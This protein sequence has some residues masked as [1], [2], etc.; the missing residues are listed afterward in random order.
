M[1]IL[2]LYGS[3]TLLNLIVVLNNYIVVVSALYLH[4]VDQLSGEEKFQ[5][6]F[7]PDVVK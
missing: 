5:P 1:K 6:H 7:L 4:A 2:H 3:I